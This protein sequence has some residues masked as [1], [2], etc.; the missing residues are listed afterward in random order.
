MHNTSGFDIKARAKLNNCPCVC[1]RRPIQ[2][3]LSSSS[4]LLQMCSGT[5]KRWQTSRTR[6]T[7][8]SSSSLGTP[9]SMLSKR[10]FST[11]KTGSIETKTNLKCAGKQHGG[12]LSGD[13]PMLRMAMVRKNLAFPSP[14]GPVIYT[15]WP[16]RMSMNRGPSLRPRSI[17]IGRTSKNT[18]P[19]VMRF[20]SS[21]VNFREMFRRCSQSNLRTSKSVGKFNNKTTRCKCGTLRVIF[22]T[23]V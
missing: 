18:V 4:S 22:K 17:R 23:I 5:C 10:D 7:A 21:K 11:K 14:S 20:N 12:C 9:K 16:W 2:S 13:M 19:G 1:E 8:S 6:A 3:A 15:S